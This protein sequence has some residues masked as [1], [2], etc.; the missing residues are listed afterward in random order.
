M[1][2]LDALQRGGTLSRESLLARLAGPR[3]MLSGY[4]SLDDQLQP[5][6]FDLSLAEVSRFASAGAIGRVNADRSLPEMIALPFD[7]TGW[8]NLAP[9]A[10][11]ILF[12]ET[13]DLPDDV[14]A[15]G[16]PRSS[17]CRCGVTLGTAVWD[18]GYH[19]RSTALLLVENPV[20]FRVQRDA[21]LMQLVFFSLTAA[22]ARGYNGAYQHE[23][24]TPDG[25]DQSRRA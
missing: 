13:V 17:L 10:Y 8:L 15:L 22:T 25:G 2:E 23:N 16:R 3:P 20:G 1:S 11:Q 14:M 6:G 21:R 19:G 18:A 4:V 5:N 24:L 12:N 9:G 7:D